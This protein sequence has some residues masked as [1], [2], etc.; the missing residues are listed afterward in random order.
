MEKYNYLKRIIKNDL[1]KVL[2]YKYP[3]SFQRVSK[4]N[5]QHEVVIFRETIDL[6]ENYD[7]LLLVLKNDLEPTLDELPYLTVGQRVGLNKWIN[8]LRYPRDV[9]TERDH[10]DFFIFRKISQYLGFNH[11]L[12]QCNHGLIRNLNMRLGQSAMRLCVDSHPLVASEFKDYELDIFFDFLERLKPKVLADS[13][14]DEQLGLDV[15]EEQYEQTFK[16][17]LDEHE[18]IY[19]FC[20]DVTIHRDQPKGEDDYLKLYSDFEDKIKAILQKVDGLNT[21]IHYLFKLEPSQEFGINLH[22]VLILKETQH[23]P[24][25]TFILKFKKELA[26][27]FSTLS[28]KYTVRNWNDVVRKHFNKKAVGFIKKSDVAAVNES[29]YWIFSYFFA[30]EQVF[31]FN[32]GFNP[33]RIKDGCLALQSSSLPTSKNLESLSKGYCILNDLSEQDTRI[34]AHRKHLAKP[35]QQYL[36]YAD[37]TYSEYSYLPV[38]EGGHLTIG[39]LLGRIEVFCETLKAVKPELFII[40]NKVLFGF[41]S[42]EEYSKM[43][44]R[45]GRMWLSIF[46]TLVNEPDLF[47]YVLKAQFRSQNVLSFVSFLQANW[48]ELQ[49]LHF[50][51][52]NDVIM[53]QLNEKMSILKNELSHHDFIKSKTSLDG[54]F[55]KLTKYTRYLLAKDVYA[56][57]IRIE[58]TIQN[59]SLNQTEQSSILTEFLRVGQSAQ[60]LSWLRGYLLRWDQYDC[61][62][63]QSRQTY[64]DLTLFFE[65]QPKLQDA[66]LPEKL[67]RYLGKFIARYNEKNKLSNSANEIHYSMRSCNIF[68]PKAEL[69]HEVLKIET[70][71]KDLRKSFLKYY[72]PYFYFLD[73]FI[74]WVDMENGKKIKRYTK[75]QEPKSKKISTTEGS[76]SS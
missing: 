67:R 76:Q 36:S 69:R 50:Q 42:P 57:R 41:F 2:R 55:K 1:Y 46:K 6:L 18:Q 63:R 73:L 14:V 13:S 37:L 66:N 49:E 71:D 25:N 58:F 12:D 24:E 51:P 29:W 35:A 27:I 64:A 62:Q 47:Q 21:L 52:L 75:G 19:V 32:L 16:T 48:R 38:N 72:L 34:F 33:H 59:K 45:L 68:A 39:Y 56:L 15:C 31:K 44:T 9:L 23:F 65:Y 10:F 7:Q 26:G 20:F 61:V 53:V 11:E 5:Q 8:G 43:H 17:P 28:D 4:R 30:V 22:F 74:L 40:P 54:N 70:I 60:P 3:L